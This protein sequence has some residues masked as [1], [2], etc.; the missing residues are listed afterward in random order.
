MEDAFIA[1][2]LWSTHAVPYRV[3]LMGKKIVWRL[4]WVQTNDLCW[5]ELLEIERFD[6]LSVSKQMIDFLLNWY[7]YLE[8]FNCIDFCL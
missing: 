5:T 6:Y 8:L 4:S 7:R 3:R 2:L 1:I